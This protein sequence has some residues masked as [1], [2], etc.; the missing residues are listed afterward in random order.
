MEKAGSGWRQGA[1]GVW[2]NIHLVHIMAGYRM[3]YGY[4]WQLMLNN[5]EGDKR[6]KIVPSLMFTKEKRWTGRGGHDSSM[7]QFLKTVKLATNLNYYPSELSDREG[8]T[9]L[10]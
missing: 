5:P 7:P 3:H 6:P 2:V 10:C 8:K 9:I 4:S 1:D